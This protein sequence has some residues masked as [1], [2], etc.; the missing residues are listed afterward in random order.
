[1]LYYALIGLAA[2]SVAVFQS[3]AQPVQKAEA[4]GKTASQPAPGPTVPAAQPHEQQRSA[5][6]ASGAISDAKGAMLA[7]ENILGISLPAGASAKVVTTSDDTLFSDTPIS[8]ADPAWLITVPGAVFTLDWPDDQEPLPD[9]KKTIDTNPLDYEV[10]LRA[11]SSAV[12]RI[13]TKP[14]RIKNPAGTVR[15]LSASD[16][17]AAVAHFCSRKIRGIEI[18]PRS[19]LRAIYNG[20][21]HSLGYPLGAQQVEVHV[22]SW[23]EQCAGR[24]AFRDVWCVEVRSDPSA[25]SQ[26]LGFEAR[27]PE[28]SRPKVS[29]MTCVVEDGTNAPYFAGNVP[30]PMIV[31]DAGVVIDPG[32]SAAGLAARDVRYR[33]ATEPAKGK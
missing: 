3:R 2:M 31:D 30:D 5:P 26:T 14:I 15:S 4:A 27:I 21:F 12:L 16:Y 13:A 32:E 6:V 18:Q 19:T 22:W 23:S 33:K 20:L 28:D 7:A 1:M 25:E 8:A 17:R 10:L 24:E 9:G 29:S 11:S